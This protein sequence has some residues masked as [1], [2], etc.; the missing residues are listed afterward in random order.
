MTNS[1]AST[2]FG[3]DL[4]S[5]K[6]RW[7]SFQRKISQ[8]YLLLEFR[9]DSLLFSE[10]YFHKEKINYL[11][12]GV[13]SLPEGSVELGVPIEPVKMSGLLQQLCQ[14]K[15]INVHRCAV[16]LPP[17]ASFLSVV[18]L[19]ASL[20]AEE[21][22][23]FVQTPDSGLQIPIPLQQTDFDL[24]PLQHLWKSD[25]FESPYLLSGVPRSLVDSLIA[26]LNL[27][28]LELCDLSLAMTTQARLLC[29]QI[30]SLD[31][32]SY[33]LLLE[34]YPECTNALIL[35]ASGPVSVSRLASIREFP[36]PD[37]S[38]VISDFALEQSYLAES[39]VIAD[40]RYLPISELDLRVLVEEAKELIIDFESS[41]MSSLLEHVYLTGSGSSHP[42]LEQ[43]LQNALGL[44]VSIFR[45]AEASGVG[46]I[47]LDSTLLSQSL[48]RLL[49][50]GLHLVPDK[51]LL[52][53]AAFNLEQSVSP[54]ADS[55]NITPLHDKSL[56]L[57]APST[58]K[59]NKPSSTNAPQDVVDHDTNVDQLTSVF[60]DSIDSNHSPVCSALSTDDSSFNPGN[61]TLDLSQD[62]NVNA[63][64][65]T[66]I[67]TSE[68]SSQSEMLELQPIS[69]EPVAGELNVAAESDSV[70]QSFLEQENQ[71][72]EMLPILDLDSQVES[73][74]STLE[75]STSLEPLSE[76]SESEDW[77]S[78]HDDGLLLNEE[79]QAISFDHDYVE[80]DGD[81]KE[82]E[83]S[84]IL[85]EAS[86]VPEQI[87]LRRDTDEWPSVLQ[88]DE[89]ES[90]L[91]VRNSS[92]GLFQEFE[93]ISLEE[94]ESPSESQN[95]SAEDEMGWPSIRDIEIAN[96]NELNTSKTIVPD[97]SINE[98]G[99][100]E[101]NS[102]SSDPPHS[103]EEPSDDLNKANNTVATDLSVLSD[104]EHQEDEEGFGELRF[105]DN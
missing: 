40:D 55:I 19:P 92:D 63:S 62:L 68:Q 94:S 22:W 93:I 16:V 37:A 23:D 46:V 43:L 15:G 13:Q 76:S 6:A 101:S 32:N 59:L 36:E 79:Q 82:R 89:S 26:T 53:S 2:V 14:E 18:H 9:N 75:L 88:T 104:P 67:N 58:L 60:G 100:N 105:T 74:P 80:N 97:V 102:P 48:G 8:R 98:F 29:S 103:L 70:V 51:I 12:L 66:D 35:S 38:E 81:V 49:G 65:V 10:V 34:F 56:L 72:D 57:S 17:E 39:I 31:L 85:V 78:I 73:P 86:D 11:N 77:P 61:M 50:L 44:P 91:E 95:L 1:S 33:I 90:V 69:I 45:V 71:D 96:E 41:N 87:D 42:G 83:C 84:D 21:A 28:G 7:T 54:S 30:V 20:S 47:S 64:L 5:L 25:E 52:Q 4:G 27:A 24:V 99:S 3:L